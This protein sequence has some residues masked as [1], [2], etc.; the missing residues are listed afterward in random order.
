MLP[1]KTSRVN[2]LFSE[3]FSGLVNVAYF[4]ISKV[5]KKRKFHDSLVDVMDQWGIKYACNWLNITVSDS[6]QYFVLTT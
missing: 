5:F 3:G 1:Q 2:D 4:A 6:F